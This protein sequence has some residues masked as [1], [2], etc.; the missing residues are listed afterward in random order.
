MQHINGVAEIAIH[1]RGG[2]SVWIIRAIGEEL[3]Q[4]GIGWNRRLN[5]LQGY[6]LVLSTKRL[7]MVADGIL[8]FFL[9]FL[10]VPKCLAMLLQGL[11]LRSLES[12][13]SKL[14]SCLFQLVQQCLVLRVGM[15]S[16]DAESIGCGVERASLALEQNCGRQSRGLPIVGLQLQIERNSP[17]GPTRH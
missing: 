3:H 1:L 15:L 9:S 6:F 14:A 5:C 11:L 17:I 13:S 16:Q 4:G 12:N 8:E 2:F 7:V 10:Q